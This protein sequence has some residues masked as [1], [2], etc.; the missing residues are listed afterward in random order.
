MDSPLGPSMYESC[1]SLIEKKIFNTIKKPK[2]YV[3]NVDDI[4]IAT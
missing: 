1:I 2:I 4:F 3:C